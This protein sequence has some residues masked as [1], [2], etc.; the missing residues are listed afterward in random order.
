M[1]LPVRVDPEAPGLRSGR[2]LDAPRARDVANVSVAIAPACRRAATG[3]MKPMNI[4]PPFYR[5][6]LD[7]EIPA[8]EV[9]VLVDAL[10]GEV[11]SLRERLGE[12]ELHRQLTEQR[13]RVE[14]ISDERWPEFERDI[15]TLSAY[16]SEP[17]AGREVR[18][19]PGPD[20]PRIEGRRILGFRGE[21]QHVALDLAWDGAARA[22]VE[23][24]VDGT[25]ARNRW[26]DLP[27]WARS[28]LA[29]SLG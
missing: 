7:V 21:A 19:E 20:G 10:D 2:G 4:D 5:Y 26:P 15:A 3:P 11:F 8:T 27:E 1:F 18:V 29:R 22:P 9:A 6:D 25:D 12:D 28:S 24:G 14:A 23:R 13:I 16:L 17:I